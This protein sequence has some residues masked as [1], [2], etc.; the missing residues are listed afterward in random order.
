V[1]IPVDLAFALGAKSGIATQE[2]DAMTIPPITLAAIRAQR[3]CADGWRKLLDALGGPDTPIN[4]LM[5]L[6]DIAHSNGAA[7]ALWCVRALDWSDVAVRRAVIAGCVLP[8]VRRAASYTQD[9][10]V[11]D[12]IAAL[13][14]WCGGEDVDLAAA[15]DAAWDAASDAARAARAAERAAAEAASDAAWAAASA[16][17]ARAASDAA[18]DAV[19]DAA[20]ADIIAASPLLALAKE[21]AA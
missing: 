18:W 1:K 8:G 19:S 10:R 9:Q 20:R 17:N 12:C 3:P 13:E 2:P 4:T 7:D 16:G 11:H 14:A 15:G 5:S 6:G 21:G